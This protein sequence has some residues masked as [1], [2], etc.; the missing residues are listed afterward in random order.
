MAYTDKVDPRYRESRR[1]HYYNNKQQYIDRKKKRILE[2]Q[3]LIYK[4]K[5]Q[6]CMDCDQQYPHYVMDFDHRDGEEKMFNVS[7]VVRMGI[8][9][10]RI[11]EEVAKCDVVCSNCHRERTHRR[12]HGVKLDSKPDCR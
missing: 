8:S 10:K 7:Y 4:I 9:H 3:Q 2:A 5:E 12:A 1:K 11:L 6:P